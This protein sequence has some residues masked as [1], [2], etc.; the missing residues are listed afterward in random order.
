M[1]ESKTITLLVVTIFLFVSDVIGQDRFH[2]VAVCDVLLDLQDF[3]GKT[4]ALIGRSTSSD[5]GWWISED[6]PNKLKTG[7]F[8]WPSM[9]WLQFDNSSESALAT[10]EAADGVS[11]RAKFLEVRQRTRL[12]SK[13][14]WVIVYGRIEAQDKLETATYS[15][16]HIVSNGF[17]HLA[18]APFQL[19]YKKEDVRVLSENEL[20]S[21]LRSRRVQPVAIRKPPNKRLQPDRASRLSPLQPAG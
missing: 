16:G 1:H 19:V 20:Q 18:G 3:R 5:E 21:I 7:E 9:G 12:R 17:G 2:P 11:F 8:E 4:V 14:A 6:C 13:E 15:L 10:G